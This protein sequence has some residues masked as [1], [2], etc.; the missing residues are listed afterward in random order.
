MNWPRRHEATKRCVSSV[1]TYAF[2]LRW[3]L[4]AVALT[5]C[6]PGIAHAQCGPVKY[7]VAWNFIGP[8]GSIGNM[9]I[10]IDPAD[11]TVSKL[12]CLARTLR[13]EN[14]EWKDV[15]V[16]IFDS[17]KAARAFSPSKVWR[18][19]PCCRVAMVEG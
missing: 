5:V 16:A 19:R 15:F 12:F 4:C 13:R 17:P 8:H 10:S 1:L 9:E 7:A 3:A 2:W 14:P 6:T 18:R 11:V